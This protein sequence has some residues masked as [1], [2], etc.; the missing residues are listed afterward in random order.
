MRLYLENNT[1]NIY[2]DMFLAQ[3]LKVRN[4]GELKLYMITE[5]TDTK[6]G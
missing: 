5:P 1:T 4:E 6:N 3:I 2:R